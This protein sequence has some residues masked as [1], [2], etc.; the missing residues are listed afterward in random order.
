MSGSFNELDVPPTLVS[1]AL[2]MTK[3]SHTGTAAFQQEGSLVA[4]LPL[5]VEEKT[6]LPDWPKVKELFDEVAKLVQYGVI[7]SASVVREGGVAAAVARMCFGNRIGFAFNR[8]VSRKTLFTP[9]LGS[10]V[11]ELKEGDMCLEGL[12]YS[13]IG[14]TLD[15]AMIVID[16]EELDLDALRDRW[17]TP[18]E[19]VFP[20]RAAQEPDEPGSDPAVYQTRG[21]GAGDKSGEAA[22]VYSGVPGHQ[23]RIRFRQSV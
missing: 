6:L 9:Q 11:V 22:G 13:L 16:G 23:L 12:S 21:E 7:R 5:P 14:T 17:M 15:E 10:L 18:L 3:A 19:A 8:D 1:F 4:F 20:N 2:A